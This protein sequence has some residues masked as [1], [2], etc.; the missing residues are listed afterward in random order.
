MIPLAGPRSHKS[1]VGAIALV[2]L[3]FSEIDFGKSA[4]L[5]TPPPYEGERRSR[6]VPPGMLPV[7]A[8]RSAS[9][10]WR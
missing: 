6:D 1:D 9:R 2:G 7:R 4:Q 8:I 10:T 5:A 3:L